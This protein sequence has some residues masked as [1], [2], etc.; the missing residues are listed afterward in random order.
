MCNGYNHKPGCNC[1]FG[2]G[3]LGPHQQLPKLGKSGGDQYIGVIRYR[4]CKKW[5]SRSILDKDKI[6]NSLVELGLKPKWVN[7]IVKQYTQA[8]YPLSEAEWDALT[9][10]QRVSKERKFLGLLG[11]RTEIVKELD[12]I[13]LKL[14]LF[15][16]Q[17]PRTEKS[18]V[19]VQETQSQA[20]GW[21]IFLEIP[22]FALGAD[23][24]LRME[25]SGTIST[26][27]D[28]CKVVYL[29]V[30]IKR[31]LVNL[32]LG[33]L[34]IAREKLVVEA[35]DKRTGQV[36]NR[37]VQ[38]RTDYIVPLPDSPLIAEYDLSEDLSDKNCEYTLSWG[39]D[40]NRSAKFTIP[41][42]QVKP[43]I[44]AKIELERELKL[45][46]SLAPRHNYQLYP[47]PEEMGISWIVS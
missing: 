19:S 29:P 37:K 21:S 43:G 36:F 41:V 20:R 46:F 18:E 7:S 11:L 44:E 8:G 35:G 47:T 26:S 5:T 12:P 1:G 3:Y 31:R 32:F 40:S 16:L 34:C 39:K 27:G 33:S 28:I 14:P 38:S 9:K 25:A 23:L 42:P 10:N 17:P 45:E 15:R 6:I 30:R 24:S 13:D 4:A 22:G 2:G